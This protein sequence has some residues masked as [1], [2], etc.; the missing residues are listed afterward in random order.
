MTPRLLDP[1]EQELQTAIRWYESKRPGLGAELLG[2]VHDVI[3]KVA[4]APQQFP[5]WDQNPRFRRAAAARFPY[6]L[7]F[8]IVDDEVVV[9]AVAHASRRPGYWLART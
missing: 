7:Y 5:P 1:A 9:V 8:H 6:A 3:V 4:E 2:A